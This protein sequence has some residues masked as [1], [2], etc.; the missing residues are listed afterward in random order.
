MRELQLVSEEGLSDTFPDI[1]EFAAQCRFRDCTHSGEPGC[2]VEPN[3]DEARLRAWS[4][5]QHEL[6]AERRRTNPGERRRYERAFSRMVDKSVRAKQKG[7][8][9]ADGDDLPPPAPRETDER[10][11]P[12]VEG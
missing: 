9:P 8:D 6:E 10:V 4:R 11:D 12:E 3:V 2:A 5:L 1:D 7:R